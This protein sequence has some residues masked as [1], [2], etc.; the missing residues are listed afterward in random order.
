MPSIRTSIPEIPAD[1]EFVLSMALAKDP[2]ARF[3]SVQAFATALEQASK[4]AISQSFYAAQ[5]QLEAQANKSVPVYSAPFAPS[6]AEQNILTPTVA[7]GS[8][9]AVQATAVPAPTPAQNPL[10][11][12]AIPPYPPLSSYPQVRQ[13]YLNQRRRLAQ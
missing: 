6:Q 11:A 7:T 10:Y 3:G 1:V 2:K 5:P 8:S 12:D 13:I 9:F 4:P